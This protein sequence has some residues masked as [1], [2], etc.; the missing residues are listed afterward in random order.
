MSRWFFV[1]L[2]LLSIFS[3]QAEIKIYSVENE[4]PLTY[5]VNP[6]LHSDLYSIRDFNNSY[7]RNRGNLTSL[8]VSEDTIL[9]NFEDALFQEKE[10]QFSFTRGG[11]NSSLVQNL[12]VKY[13]EEGNVE[14]GRMYFF[15]QDC[16][17]PPVFVSE[18]RLDRSFLESM[19]FLVP[20]K[21]YNPL[22]GEEVAYGVDRE[23]YEGCLDYVYTKIG[24]KI[25]EI[26]GP[27]R[28]TDLVTPIISKFRQL[29]WSG[30]VVWS[31]TDAE[32]EIIAGAPVENGYFW[33][34]K[35]WRKMILVFKQCFVLNQ[36]FSVNFDWRYVN[37]RNGN[38]LNVPVESFVRQANMDSY[39]AYIYKLSSNSWGAL[40][41]I[42]GE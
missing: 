11:M 1:F 4:C 40:D 28:F 18:G 39:N 38:M 36:S 30:E 2:F 7:A 21:D 13:G 26:S 37:L 15:S 27:E 34:D 14:N 35:P 42:V 31:E 9:A 41:A 3:V 29:P 5:E 16:D 33:R 32:K 24:K 25:R 19:S 12:I 22:K 6:T 8:E 20:R 23:H 10:L 17:L